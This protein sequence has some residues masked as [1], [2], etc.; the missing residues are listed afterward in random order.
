M[1]R[2]DERASGSSL[3]ETSGR[4]R[5]GALANQI[6]GVRECGGKM[7]RP[8]AGLSFRLEKLAN[9]LKRLKLS[10]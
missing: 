8:Q 2:T 10:G 4:A 5:E 9:R 7:L 3:A 6:R 1:R